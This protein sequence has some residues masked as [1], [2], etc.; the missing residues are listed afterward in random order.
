M[1]D[2]LR[3][4]LVE[5]N[6][7]DAR[8]V[9][10]FLRDGSLGALTLEHRE[11]L[12]GAL[13]ALA[14][15]PFDAVLLDL[16]LPDSQGLPTLQSVVQAAPKVPVVVLTGLH[17]Q[18]IARAAVS[19]GAQDYLPK[20][21]LTPELLGR[22]LL[23]AIER[24]AVEAELSRHRQHLEELV[25]ARTHELAEA[26]E[27]AEAASRAKSQFLANVSHELRTPMNAILGFTQLMQRDAS[28]SERQR[29]NLKT[30][31]SSGEHLL[32]LINDVL[33]I[34]KIEAGRLQVNPVPFD[35][36][37]LVESLGELF[38]IRAQDKGLAIRVSLDPAV[39][40]HVTG[41]LQ[42]L[43]QGLMNL[44]GNAVKFTDHGWV[45]LEV[46]LAEPGRVLFAVRD[47]GVGIEPENRDKV[48]DAFAQAAEGNRRGEGTGLGLTI[49]K[50]YA[51]LMG[52]QLSLESRPREGS[53]FCLAIPLPEAPPEA[54]PAA[55]PE[56]VVLGLEPGQGGLR[57]LIVED[58]EPNRRFLRQVLEGAG[59][60]VQEAPDGEEAIR[61]FV[62]WRP[63][64]I[65]MDMRMPV[66]DGYAATRRIRCLPGGQEVAIVAL[67]ASAFEEDKSEVLAAGCDDFMRK[68]V[69][70]EALF[71][72]LGKHLGVRFRY[73]EEIAPA[74]TRGA[75]AAFDWGAIEG[76]DPALRLRLRAAAEALDVTGV[77]AVLTEVARVDDRLAGRL[78][79]LAGEFQ[80]DRIIALVTPETPR[81]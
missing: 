41:D 37:D 31:N 23:Y 67:T 8:L 69:K 43:R 70:I 3:I 58:K 65:W 36:Q 32:A 49:C 20:G 42:K 1:A 73:G 39:P 75:G 50:R 27:A 80:F 14:E 4:L 64:L 5:D 34:T 18:A 25:A 71:A 12:D 17:D 78:T 68:P 10:E 72:M 11:R 81:R 9:R 28:L 26:K 19:A 63:H 16:S 55:G 59:F 40:R 61:R 22:V 30:I 13:A 79:A 74:A 47:T 66:L 45:A 51:E 2:A 56:R 21:E 77:Q 29:G 60:E 15:G 6:P 33:E 38:R 48:F 7:G 24:K 44:L 53:L 76:L 62:T 46:G 35:L 54:L 57:I 52:G